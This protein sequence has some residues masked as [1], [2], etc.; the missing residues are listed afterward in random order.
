MHTLR[1]YIS[2]YLGSGLALIA[3]SHWLAK[4]T[5]LSMTTKSL[6]ACKHTH[7]H[8]CTHAHT[9]MHTCTHAHTHMHTCT[10][11][12]THICTHAHIH[13]HICTH[14]HMHT[15]TVTSTY[16]HS[17]NHM[18]THDTMSCLYKCMHITQWNIC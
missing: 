4:L 15:H 18:C 17:H 9:H 7:M 12:H 10:H 5:E 2:H 16:I 6:H 3:W 8:T 13:T 14:A 11:A 1:P